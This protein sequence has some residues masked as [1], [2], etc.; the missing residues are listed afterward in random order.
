MQL[1]QNLIRR[2]TTRHLHDPISVFIRKHQPGIAQVIPQGVLFA[3]GRRVAG[4]YAEVEVAPFFVVDGFDAEGAC[5]RRLAVLDAGGVVL[6]V[7]H[8]GALLH[9]LAQLVA[10]SVVDDLDGIACAEPDQLRQ[11]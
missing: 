1:L 11:I 5:G 10:G 9:N 2:R 7:L 8:R 3:P 4:V 6:L